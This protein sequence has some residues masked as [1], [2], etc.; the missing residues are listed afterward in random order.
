MARKH[1]SKTTLLTLAAILLLTACKGKPWNDPYPA[2]DADANV[3]YASFSEQPK[4]LD[5]AQSYSVD[6]AVFTAQIYE[7]PLQYHYLKRPYTLI[8]LTATEVP[9][10][11]FLDANDEEL[12]ADTA[13]KN[14]V[15]TVYEIHIQPGINYQPH[16]AFAKKPDGSYYY[17]NLSAAD[18][19]D[20]KSLA[21]FT[22][23]GTRELVADDYVYEIKRLAD[24]RVQ[25]PIF[26]F[27]GKYIQGFTD[28][29]AQLKQN[30]NVDLRQ[31]PLQ[32]TQ[33]VDKYTYKIIINGYYPQFLYWLAMPFFAPVPWEADAFYQQPGLANSN[34]SLA[35]YPIGTG[36]YMLE[37]NN[38]NRQMVMTR[39]PN[40]HKEYYPMEGEPGDLKAGLLTKAGQ[41]L[42]FIDKFVFTLEKESIPRWN[43]FLQGYYDQSA[44]SSDSFDQAIKIDSAGSPE[45]T[46]LI[47][48]RNISLQT[49]VSP[50]NY[51]L[52]FNMLD[53]IVGRDSERARKL[54]LAIA[55]AMNYDEYIAIFLNG[56]GVLAQGP[57]PPGIFGYR[58]GK[59]GI[60]PF[61]YEWNNNNQI[62]RKSLDEAKQLLKEA[63]YPNGRDLTT[64]EA[65]LLNF[66]VMSGGTADDQ[67]FYSWM[68]KE[69]NQLGIQ[70]Q[71]RDTQ[72]SRF[73]EKLRNGQAQIFMWGWQADY[74]DPENFLFLLYGP[75]GEVK[76][77]GE[78]ATNYQNDQYD[79]LFK[80]MRNLPNGEARQHIID[81]MVAIAWHD[82]PAVWGFYP[83]GFLLT[84]SWVAPTKPNE[85]A[86]NTLKFLSIDPKLRAELRDSWNQPILWPLTV[87]VLII[88]AGLL[89]IFYYYWR[90]QHR[91]VRDNNK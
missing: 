84:Q 29:N 19:A 26:G 31:V 59:E 91:P 10:P 82:S 16:P 43:K 54:R 40:Y 18:L 67:A 41:Q 80:K 25:S 38:P 15:R 30:N 39:N 20:K 65:L 3:Y 74:P 76:Y 47:K 48:A 33:V 53:S 83:Q 22:Q 1:L 73:Q 32:G 27:L 77:G 42:P 24:P 8:P 44:I 4:T 69:F 55:T 37:E 75:N 71:I 5:P 2:A 72:Y 9:K 23:T 79:A 34:I 36:A 46:P 78:N 87:V 28:F 50:G 57:I 58:E 66:D 88:L 62:Q 68:R 14:I 35:W 63:G 70:L 11:I 17:H 60:N 56:R 7:P 64:D 51:Y 12:P 81:Q 6:E 86:N 89:P 85:I 52:G 45:I 61:V 21:D 49:S 90:R 13:K